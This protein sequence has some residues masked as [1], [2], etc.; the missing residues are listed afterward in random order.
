MAVLQTRK[1]ALVAKTISDA[2]P[3]DA[4]GIP[5]GFIGAASGRKAPDFLPAYNDALLLCDVLGGISLGYVSGCFYMRYGHPGLSTHA[6]I[7]PMVREVMLGSVIAALILREPRLAIDGE[8]FAPR[9]LLAATVLRAVVGISILLTIGLVTRGFGDMARLWLL[10]WCALYF[11]FAC[12]SRAVVVTHLHLLAMNGALREAVAVVGA[13]DVAGRLAARLA[14]SAA[15]VR[16]FDDADDFDFGEPNSVSMAE[17]LELARAGEVDTVVV[18]LGAADGIDAR[19]I[20]QHLKSMPIQVTICSNV[21]APA[22]T[23][24]K[25]R[26]LSSVPMS[27]VADRPLKHWDLIAKAAVDR[28]GALILLLLAM[29]LILFVALAVAWDST[30]PVIFRQRRSGWGGR[31]FTIYKFRTMWHELAAASGRQTVRNDPRC[32]RV[33]VILRRYG[34]DEIPQLWNVLRGD[35]SLIGP[36]PHADVL[37][38]AERAGCTL[39]AEYAQ[40]HRVK[41]G[42]TGWAQIHGSRG[43]VATPEALRQRI[44]YDLYYIDN[45]S[46][47]LDLA[48]LAR[49]P[50]ALLKGENAY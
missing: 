26:L 19:P 13:P 9:R 40:R 17:L 31:V 44:A 30:G 36:R 4:R 35:M 45:W 20:V 2:G 24:R 32:T 43:A 27:V 22:T 6:I 1:S 23:R 18:A 11:A 5:P 38:A 12:L 15:V 48:I 47:W 46:V 50:W 7:G 37:H 34:I 21:D 8:L 29:P 33:G 42:L 49:T 14:E 3:T 28:I 16:V 25:L 41:P 39:V 10:G